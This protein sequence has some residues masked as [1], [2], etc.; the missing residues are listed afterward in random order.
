M[1]ERERER[2]KHESTQKNSFKRR[3]GNTLSIA[4]GKMGRREIGTI[5]LVE[6]CLVNVH[7]KWVLVFP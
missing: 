4:F 2:E 7:P 5:E 6:S 1:E 3:N